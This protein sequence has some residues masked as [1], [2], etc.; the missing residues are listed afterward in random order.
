M[1]DRNKALEDYKAGLSYKE[2]AEKH[3]I[4]ESAVKSWASRY[5]NKDKKIKAARNKAKKSQPKAVKSC[6]LS[7]EKKSQEVTVA[8]RH[9]GGQPG[10][11]NALGSQGPLK[12]GGYSS[13]YW[14]VLDDEER[15]IITELDTDEEYQLEEQLRLYAVREHRILKAIQMVKDRASKTG[16]VE[17]SSSVFST[18]ENS[19][20]NVITDKGNLETETTSKPKL[21]ASRKNYEKSE[22]AV[23]RLEKELTSI[24]RNKTK[25]INLLAEL[26]SHKNGNNDEWLDDFFSAINE[27]NDEPKE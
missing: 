1:A 4:T 9:K 5:W 20:K 2:I 18:F 16:D 7:N 26:R 3:S 14:D 11:K 15:E 10:N 12:H 21:T 23:A 6:N 8:K 17:T 27:V 24:Q 22:F 13:V 25:V 19:D